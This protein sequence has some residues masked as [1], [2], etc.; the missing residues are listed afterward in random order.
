MPEQMKPLSMKEII[1]ATM[2]GIAELDA[3]CEEIYQTNFASYFENVRE[4]Y[5]KFKKSE[6][7]PISDEDLSRILIEV[8]LSLFSASEA[9]QKLKTHQEIM[10]LNTKYSKLSLDDT[11]DKA[12]SQAM[13]AVTKA[14]ENIITR[15][16][17]EI[18]YSRELIMGAKKI[19]DARKRTESLMPVSE[20]SEED[21]KR[22]KKLP[23]YI[24]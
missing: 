2:D 13:E 18:S 19:W 17:K 20:M 7:M 4:L 24:K 21:S 5:I 11:E 15:A 16:E 6:Y 3:W 23:E 22:S 12:N 9:V 1:S 14:Y 10:K 8:P